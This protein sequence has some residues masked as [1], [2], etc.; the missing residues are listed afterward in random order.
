[1]LGFLAFTNLLAGITPRSG[2]HGNFH[3]ICSKVSKLIESL[4]VC[5]F[6]NFS[7]HILFKLRISVVV[8]EHYDESSLWRK[9]LFHLRT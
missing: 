7:I 1:M 8:I 5:L 3:L 2:F 9:D 6:V 4:F